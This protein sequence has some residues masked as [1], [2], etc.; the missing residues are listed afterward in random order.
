MATV[1]TETQSANA[2]SLRRIDTDDLRDVEDN[3]EAVEFLVHLS[4]TPSEAWRQ[5]FEQAY[6]HTPYVLKPPVTLSGDA[7]HIIYLPRYGSELPG[8]IR[9]LAL[10]ARRADE[11]VRKT[12]QIQHSSAQDKRRAEFREVLR[13]IELPE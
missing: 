5:E 13:R 11:E 7:L 2:I 4:A 10:I 8:F 12:E 1:T 3:N 6:L 9:F